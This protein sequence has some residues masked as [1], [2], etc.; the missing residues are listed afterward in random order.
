MAVMIMNLIFF[1]FSPITLIF[2]LI[3]YRI[4]TSSI[5]IS[6]LNYAVFSRGS[7]PL[8]IRTEPHTIH[9]ILMALLEYQNHSYLVLD[10]QHV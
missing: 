1:L 8:S 9:S 4:S 2:L 7:Y 6:N 3:G 5:M 10:L